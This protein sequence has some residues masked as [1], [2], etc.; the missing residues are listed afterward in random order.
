M[1]FLSSFM[2]VCSA[3]PWHAGVVGSTVS[4]RPWPEMASERGLY[5]VG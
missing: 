1:S 5:Y 4:D 2:N 3:G